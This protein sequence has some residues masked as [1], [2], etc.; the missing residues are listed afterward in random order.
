MR[1]VLK[2]LLKL[3]QLLALVLAFVTIPVMAALW[4]ICTVTIFI[5]MQIL[6]VLYPSLGRKLDRMFQDYFI[7]SL[8]PNK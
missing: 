3:S 8:F 7:D 2:I 4:V 5:T 6:V 1:S